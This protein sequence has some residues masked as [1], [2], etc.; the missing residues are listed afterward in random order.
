[1]A[2]KNKFDNSKKP[3]ATPMQQS[4]MPDADEINA[5]YGLEPVY[6][7]GSDPRMQPLGHFVSVRCPHCFER[8]DTDV[9]TIYGS[10]ERIEDCQICCRPIELRI[11]I[12]NGEVKRLSAERAG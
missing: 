10:F 1:M 3:P 8:Y 5:R 9:E 4:K 7:A 2:L 6:E 12:E 11:E